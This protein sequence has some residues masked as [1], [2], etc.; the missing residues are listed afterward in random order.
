M[1]IEVFCPGCKTR[2]KV[3]DKFAGK[4]GPCPKCKTVIT[5]PEKMPEVV[6]HAPE[7]F[8]PKNAAGVGVLKPI[9]RKEVRISAV[10]VVGIVSGVILVLAAAWILRS[11]GQVSPWVKGLGALVLAPPLVLAGYTFLRDDELE[12]YRGWPLLIRVVICSLLYAALW[13]A[14]AWL[15]AL[16]FHT[17]QLGLLDLLWLV[18]PIFVAGAFIGAFAFDLEYT[19]AIFHYGLY[20]LVTVAL[21]LLIGIDVLSVAAPPA[22]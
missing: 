17:Y 4:K 2:F 12:P 8:G 21:C 14:Y 3:S 20:V 13:G 11:L 15:P 1:P 16:A 18:P 10:A 7:E 19:N 22:A 6:V 5:V 9:A